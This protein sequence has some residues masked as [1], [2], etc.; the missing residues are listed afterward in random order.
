M[1]YALGESFPVGKN[2]DISLAN[3]ANSLQWLFFFTFYYVPNINF[4][5][6]ISN[7]LGTSGL[8]IA[9]FNVCTFL[10]CNQQDT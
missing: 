4:I 10:G 2:L 6:I 3:A 5:E 8:P 9:A 7:S 1:G